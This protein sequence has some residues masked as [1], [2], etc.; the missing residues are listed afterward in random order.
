LSEK[1]DKN[2][3]ENLVK[4][5]KEDFSAFE[6]L[7]DFY[8]PKIY[9]YILRRVSN[10]EEAED[11]VSLTFEKALAGIE[12]FEI[13]KTIRFSSWLYRIAT[14][15]IADYFR[16]TLKEK[17]VDFEEVSFA[18][19][20]ETQEDPESFAKKDQIRKAIM[21]LPAKYRQ[22][23][24]LKFYEGLD[25]Q[26]MAETLGINKGNLA[27]KLYRSLKSLKKIIEEEK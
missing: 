11:L 9:G 12:K 19:K 25:N 16:K 24:T 6:E 1:L 15:N 3:E 20:D 22:I 21:K 14:N 8:M 18:L 27:V 7:Y 17:K 26:E 2:K 23:I 4:Q 5:A 10:K 13:Q